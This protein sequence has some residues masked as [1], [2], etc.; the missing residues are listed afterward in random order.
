[1]TGTMTGMTRRGATAAL[2][3]GSGMGATRVSAAPTLLTMRD[4]VKEGDSACVYHCDFG[5]ARRFSQMLDN[6]RNHLE[7]YEFNPLALQL[8]IVAHAAG[9][10]FFLNDLAGTPWAADPVEGD[11]IK[12]MAALGGHGVRGYLCATTF[13]KNNI[14]QDRARPEAWLRMV[15][16]GVAMVGAL[17]TKGFAYVKIG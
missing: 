10:R 4:I 17:Q 15:P 5:D 8:V 14:P 2:A 1:M 3:A 7:A 13:A 12:R 16:S 6:A 11:V 9:I